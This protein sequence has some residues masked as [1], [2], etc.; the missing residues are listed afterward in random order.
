MMPAGFTVR[1]FLYRL[2]HSAKS[3][4]V[5]RFSLGFPA[6][7]TC[8]YS[9]PAFPSSELRAFLQKPDLWLHGVSRTSATIATPAAFNFLT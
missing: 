3:G 2:K 8:M 7:L 1:Y 9:I 5:R 6:D 4:A